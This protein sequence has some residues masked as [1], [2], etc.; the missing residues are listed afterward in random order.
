MQ[1]YRNA[2]HSVAYF[3]AIE[4]IKKH[5]SQDNIPDFLK[6]WMEKLVSMPKNIV[7]EHDIALPVE[8]ADWVRNES[9]KFKHPVKVITVP[10]IEHYSLLYELCLILVK[11]PGFDIWGFPVYVIGPGTQ[12]IYVNPLSFYILNFYVTDISP[13]AKNFNNHDW[14]ETDKNGVEFVFHYLHRYKK[15]PDNHKFKSWHFRDPI[16][17]TVMHYAALYGCLPDDLPEEFL[18][19]ENKDGVTVKQMRTIRLAF[20]LTNFSAYAKELYS[21]E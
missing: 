10:E 1:E 19:M 20:N 9:I 2:N 4:F 11:Q 13:F 12:F 14:I 18:T 3:S 21:G 5:Q 15:F 6:T 7:M 16:G 17:N 8:T